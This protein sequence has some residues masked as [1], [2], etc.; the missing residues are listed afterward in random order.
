M[1]IK[2]PE[3]YCPDPIY[4]VDFIIHEQGFLKR[5]GMAVSISTILHDPTARACSSPPS[6]QARRRRVPHGGAHAGKLPYH[7]A[8]VHDSQID[9]AQHDAGAWASRSEEFLPCFD[10]AED[11]AMAQG[12]NR[13]TFG[14][15]RAMV[16]S[17]DGPKI[18]QFPAR[19]P[20]VPTKTHK[21]HRDLVDTHA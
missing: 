15:R 16:G 6:C 5:K 19:V 17:P 8:R 10:A 13:A 21:H 2:W 3:F 11:A 12:D 20:V 1:E 4:T 18:R 7:G 9:R 14:H